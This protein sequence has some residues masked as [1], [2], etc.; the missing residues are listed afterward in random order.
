ME[1]CNERNPELGLIEWISEQPNVSEKF[2][3][4]IKRIIIKV[5]AKYPKFGLSF[6]PIFDAQDYPD[7]GFELN[8]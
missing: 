5:K 1:Y 8:K 6:A 2:K 4:K 3:T 7:K